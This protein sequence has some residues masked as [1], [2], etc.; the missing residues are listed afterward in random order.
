MREIASFAP[1]HVS[2]WID[3]D[4]LYLGKEID[5]TLSTAIKDVDFVVVFISSK[6]LESEWVIKELDLAL[7]V[8]K[9]RGS[10]CALPVLLEDV[11]E[12]VE[13]EEF[14][15]RKYLECFSRTRHDVE[16]FAAKLF[17]ELSALR[18]DELSRLKTRSNNNLVDKETLSGGVSPET[19][20]QELFSFKGE[21]HLKRSWLK[22]SFG[23]FA[24]RK[25]DSDVLKILPIIKRSVHE[26][27]KEIDITDPAANI[28]VVGS[29]RY[30]KYADKVQETFD[31]PFQ[32]VTASYDSNRTNQFIN[33]VTEYGDEFAAS[34]DQRIRLEGREVDYGILF[35]GNL[36]KGFKLMWIAGIHG[37]GTIGVAKYLADNASSILQHTRELNGTNCGMAY[38]IRV[39][40]FQ[41]PIEAEP[42][43]FTKIELIGG[44]AYCK[45]KNLT[46]APNV[47][48]SDLGNVLM[49]FDRNR[50]Y[51]AIAHLLDTD[52][53]KIRKLVESSDIRDR[54]ELG[55][56]DDQQF[57]QELRELLKDANVEATQLSDEFLDEF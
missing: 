17:L 2:C 54:Y 1:R 6:S 37:A 30:N 28:I 45:I 42:E 34:Q 50:T 49:Y 35:V 52:F 25:S 9:K 56:L 5:G 19:A 27:L 13:H 14:R 16:A 29:T 3:E 7:N 41:K 24:I 51:R 10:T 38:L 40:Y 18:D 23:K 33:V 48:I 36:T 43:E 21:T 22:D 53:A 20:V 55:T 4:K 15:K 11:W 47:H 32:F 57:I 12:K 31:L 44:L 26:S 46:S 39:Q 8:E